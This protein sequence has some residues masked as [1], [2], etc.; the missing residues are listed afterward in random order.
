MKTLL[1]KNSSQS[2]QHNSKATLNPQINFSPQSPTSTTQ[3]NLKPNPKK[4]LLQP[5]FQPKNPIKV[6]IQYF[7]THVFSSSSAPAT[8]Q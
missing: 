8:W 1:I 5:P 6:L 7:Y 3:Q 2:S 4:L